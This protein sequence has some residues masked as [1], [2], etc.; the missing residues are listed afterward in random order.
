MSP[1]KVL[2]RVSFMLSLSPWAGEKGKGKGKR[3]TE[4]SL[5]L[6]EGTSPITLK[7]R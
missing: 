7:R 5:P 6:G 1:F 4:I 3:N 2:R